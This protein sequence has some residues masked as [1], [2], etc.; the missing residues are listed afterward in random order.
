VTP[1]TQAG[2]DEFSMTDKLI[3]PS[4]R[5][6][7][8]LQDA[9]FGWKAR[10]GLV[11][12]SLGWT[13]EHEWPR[14]LPKGVSYLVSRVPLKATTPEELLKM[15]E[16][17][18]EAASLLSSAEVD[19]ICY[20]CTVE[21]IL[22]GIDYDKILTDNLSKTTGVPA[23][24]MASAVV[25]ALKHLDAKKIAIVTPYIEEINE[26]ETRF[27]ESLGHEVVYE[28]G[29]GISSTIE[30]A[31]ISPATVVELGREAMARAPNADVLFISCGNL[32]TI[33]A[34]EILEKTIGKPVISSNQ[35]ML[36]AALR[37]VGVTESLRGWGTLLEVQ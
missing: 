31:R 34:I 1:K 29:L 17:A 24:T 36:W 33:E 11:T 18:V 6:D 20:G 22:Q 3:T 28:K 9:E 21:T 19:L 4:P 5:T 2:K 26:R 27:M 32:R 7:G 37:T 35:A 16:H 12:P 30:I 13:I 15:G 14:M 10:L 25:A 8:W 23:L